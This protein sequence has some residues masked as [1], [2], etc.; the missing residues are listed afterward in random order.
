M[1]PREVIVVDDHSQD[2]TPEIAWKG[3]CR[4]ILSEDLPEGWTGKPWGCWQGARRA[5]GGLFLFL[6]ADTFLEEDGLA[7]LVSTYLEGKGFSQSSPITGWKSP[8]SASP[9]FS[10]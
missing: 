6:D 5:Q 4:V 9:R 3:G 8:T 2:A 7:K 10:T 1:K